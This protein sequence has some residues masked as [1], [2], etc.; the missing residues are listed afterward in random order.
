MVTVKRGPPT[1]SSSN[2]AAARAGESAAPPV[3]SAIGN[4][5]FT[6]RGVPI[7]DLPIRAEQVH[8]ALC[9]SMTALVA[10]GFTRAP[11][12]APALRRRHAPADARLSRPTSGRVVEISRMLDESR[13]GSGLVRRER[14][15]GAVEDLRG[16]GHQPPPARRPGQDAA[17]GRGLSLCEDSHGNAANQGTVTLREGEIG[18]GDEI[19]VLERR[20]GSAALWL[21]QEPGEGGTG[22]RIEDRRSPRSS[23][24]SRCAVPRGATRRRRAYR[25]R[26]LAMRGR[27]MPRRSRSARASSRRRPVRAGGATSSA[28]T[29]PRS[30]TWTCSPCRTSRTYSLSRFL[31]SRKPTCRMAVNVAS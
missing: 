15:A 12:G 4:V 2:L 3:P 11:R 29:T 30:V 9:G 27:R 22:L 18:R 10:A 25:A 21:A 13:P 31:S 24:M 8:R 7:R 19:G 20:P 1:D 28:T 16:D 6:T 14:P 26:P 23:S 17:H 5:V